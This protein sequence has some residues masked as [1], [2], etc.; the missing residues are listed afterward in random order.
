MQTKVDM[1]QIDEIMRVVD[2]KAEYTDLEVLKQDISTKV[3]KH[4]FEMLQV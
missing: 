3:H 2:K 1:Q 4:D